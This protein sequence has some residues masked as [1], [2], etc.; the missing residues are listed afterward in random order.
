M[1]ASPYAPYYFFPF[2]ALSVMAYLSLLGACLYV[3]SMK[4]LLIFFAAF[5]GFL[6]VHIYA[7]V[8]K[9]VRGPVK[10]RTLYATYLHCQ[11]LGR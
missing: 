10:V 5:L 11:V 6:P 3:Y 9:R 4:R 7:A 2:V 1:T 8:Y